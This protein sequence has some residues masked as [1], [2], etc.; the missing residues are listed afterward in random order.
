MTTNLREAHAPILSQQRPC[1][2][3]DL[4]ESPI[5]LVWVIKIQVEHRA[6]VEAVQQALTGVRL[7]R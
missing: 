6:A 5:Y 3:L 1:A 4:A 2:A 7:S